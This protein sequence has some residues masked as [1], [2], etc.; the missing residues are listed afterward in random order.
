MIRRLFFALGAV[1]FFAMAAIP[2]RAEEPATGPA[3]TAAEKQ[4][5]SP[6]AEPSPENSSELLGEEP[7]GL[8]KPASMSA[9]PQAAEDWTKD[10]PVA[11]GA[12]RT[13]EDPD[14]AAAP[15][16]ASREAAETKPEAEPS[17]M[18][19]PAASQG[20]ATQPAEPAVAAKPVDEPSPK[21][22]NIPAAAPAEA[23]A[24]KPADE[25]SPKTQ[26]IPA[27]APAETVAAMP[28]EE[29]SPKT[30]NIPAA[31]PA[32]T[33]AAMPVEEPSPKTTAAAPAEAEALRNTLSSIPAG[34]S[35]EERNERAALVSFYESRGYS[36]LWTALGT[37]FTPKASALEAE[38]KR[39]K[40]WGLDPRDFPLPAG[41]GAGS[42]AAQSPQD[43]AAAEMKISLAALKYGRY[44]R[45]GRIINPSEQLSSYLDRRPQLIKPQAILDDLAAADQVDAYL[46][47]LHPKHPQFERLRQKYLALVPRKREGAEAKRLLANM[48]EWRWMPDDMGDVY[49]WNNI[50]EYTQRVMKDGLVVRK[51]A[52]VTG[53][54]DKQTPIFSR[55]LRKI[56]FKPTWIVPDSI[57]V[58]ELLPNLVRG[59][60]LMREWGLEVLRDGEPI[61]WRKVDW[62]ATDIRNFEVIQPNGPKSVMGKVKFSFPSQ[63]TVFMHDA[64]ERDKWM[65]RVSKRTYSHGCMRVQ[66]PIGLAEIILRE[67]KGWDTAKTRESLNKGGNN[68]EIPIEHKVMV[69][70]T[71]FTALVDDDGKLHTFP[72][73]YG[74][75]RRIT[76]ALEGKWSQIVKGRDH[77]APVELNEAN[78]RR[79][80]YADDEAYEQSMPRHTSPYSSYTSRNTF[81][82]SLFGRS[83]GEYEQYPAAPRPYQYR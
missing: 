6:A 39:S 77:L 75:E 2:S 46:R 12:E 47:G 82:D 40:D 32:E 18:E 7:S 23:V 25:P 41:L 19:E 65:F 21:T 10:P 55:Q 56:T 16:P 51:E 68:N 14:E 83:S 4:N 48:E 67:D 24:A 62:S 70:M 15:A 72:D 58:R 34:T 3:M 71:Y 80:Y 30:Q 33:V 22:Q 35:D 78:V 36:P 28:V 26:N 54:M 63:H 38:I 81:L 76:L 5:V 1:A 44:A 13:V 59:G 79:R 42:A 64:L 52:I 50:P 8:E 29:P 49:V 73:V 45:G 27:A 61:N 69:H 57:K 9:A 43:L 20:I 11:T 53:Q 31:A 66:N 60:S 74:H 37:G 17:P